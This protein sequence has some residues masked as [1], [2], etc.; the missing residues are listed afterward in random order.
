MGIRDYTLSLRRLR[1]TAQ[2]IAGGELF[3]DSEIKDGL[4]QIVSYPR[5]RPHRE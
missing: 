1:S 5:L 3:L 2:Y 4:E